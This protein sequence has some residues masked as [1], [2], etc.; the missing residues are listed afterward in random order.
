M[1]RDMELK[2]Q[3]LDKDVDM[4]KYAHKGDAAFDLRASVDICV[5]KGEKVLVC[6]GIKMA[7]PEGY[8]G[9]IWDRSGLAAKNSIHCLAGVV[10]SSYRGEVKVV[11]INLGEEEFHIKKGM[12]IAQM[13]IQKIENPEII[14]VEDLN[15]TCRGEG[16]FGSTGLH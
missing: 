15:E 2:I 11:L 4:V 9:F 14:K 5:E 13:V 12:R 7:I 16:G 10:D 8:A 6:T 3:R 1:L